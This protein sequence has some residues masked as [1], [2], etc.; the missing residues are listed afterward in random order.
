[1]SIEF[2]TAAVTVREAVPLTVPE[3]AVTV[4]APALTPVASPVGS[5]VAK[6]IALDVQMTLLVM[7]VELPSEKMPLA[8]NAC[9]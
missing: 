7:S 6:L 2:N 4:A 3:V 1:M 5:I 8:A 9:V